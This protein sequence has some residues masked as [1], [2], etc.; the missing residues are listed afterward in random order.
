MRCRVQLQGG[1]NSEGIENVIGK[2]KKTMRLGIELARVSTW[3][4]VVD[5]NRRWNK[6]PLV[7]KRKWDRREPRLGAVARSRKMRTGNKIEIKEVVLKMFPPG[8]VER[9]RPRAKVPMGVGGP[10]RIFSN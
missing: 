6:A 10:V 5:N 3:Q 2:K 9:A 1:D 8:K 4:D 7:D